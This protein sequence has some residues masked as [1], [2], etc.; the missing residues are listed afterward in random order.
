MSL[1]QHYLA[2]LL[3][4]GAHGVQHELV[5]QAGQ[6]AV[7]FEGLNSISGTMRDSMM[8]E[9]CHLARGNAHLATAWLGACCRKVDCTRETGSLYSNLGND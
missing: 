3:L 4:T 9:Q 8:S 5:A 7:S 1:C 6:I 2:Q